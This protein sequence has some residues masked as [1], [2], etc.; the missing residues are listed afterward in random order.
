M[1][2]EAASCRPLA[3]ARICSAVHFSRPRKL[4]IRKTTLSPVGWLCEKCLACTA[5][6]AMS[7]G[8]ESRL[9]CPVNKLSQ[10]FN[11]AFFNEICLC[12]LNSKFFQIFGTRLVKP[13]LHK[14]LAH[15][16]RCQAYFPNSALTPAPERMGL[17]KVIRIPGYS[18]S[19]SKKRSLSSS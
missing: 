18:S 4:D 5:W 19:A 10:C 3:Q 2:L 16:K 11:N 7:Y 12:Q 17:T 8:A 6:P 15:L 9:F 13:K 14:S 1:T